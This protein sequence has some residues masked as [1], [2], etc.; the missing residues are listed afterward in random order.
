M[1][2]ARANAK[3][4][5]SASLLLALVAP[6]KLSSAAS[7][8]R[9]TENSEFYRYSMRSTILIS[10]SFWG[11]FWIDGSSPENALHSYAKIAKIGGLEP[12]ENAAKSWLSSLQ[13][14]WLLLI[15]NADDQ[16]MD[17]MRNF[18]GGERGIIVIT[19]RNPT[20]IMYGTEDKLC[21]HFEKLEEEEAGDLLLA[22]AAFPRPW[23][24]PT[25][26]Q[27][28][29]VAQVL[30][31]LPLALIHAGKAILEKLCSLGDYTEYYERSWNKIRRNR[32]RSPSRGREVEISSMRVYS[33]YEMIY[34]GL[35]SKQDQRSKDALQLLKIFSFFHRENIEL[36]LLKTAAMNPRREREDA[37]GKEQDEVHV[38]NHAAPRGWRLFL[39]D[40]II[41]I[42]GQL[43]SPNDILPE[44]LRDD[45]DAPF[46]EDRLRL[47]L[48]LLV[49]L[50]M[51]TLQDE[52]NSYWMHPLVHTWVRQ[53][54]GTS[55]AEQ[56]IWCRAAA[57]VLAQ[58]VLFRAPRAYVARNER[59]QRQ[60]RLHVEHVLQL[61]DTIS[62]RFVENQAAHR[63]PWPLSWLIP[64]PR[65]GVF[66][67][68]EYAKFSLVYL[69]CGEYTK[70]EKLQLQV[71]DYLFTNLGPISKSGIDIALLLS[72]NYVLQTR[73]NEA[74][75]L[76]RQALESA[77]QYYGMDHPKTLQVMDTLG[78]T[79][80]MCSR[81]TEAKKLHEEVIE[82]LSGL[83]KFGPD[84]EST[85]TAVDNLSKV[86]LRFFDNVEAV[87]L[88]RQA[89]M[90]FEKI[91]GPSHQKTLEAKDNLAGIYGYI[92]EDQLPLAHQMSDEVL[93]IRTRD[94]GR[95]HPFTLKSMLTLAKIKTAL[96][97][98]EEAEAIFLEG[99]PAAER[100]LGDSHLGTLTARVWLAHLYWRQGKYSKAATIWED[101]IEKRNFQQSKREDGE[102][103]DRGRWGCSFSE[104]KSTMIYKFDNA[105]LTIK[106]NM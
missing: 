33:S 50:G 42:A 67:A 55:T 74:R 106:P 80:L 100:N 75:A 62:R 71:K 97:Q 35:E 102:H 54:P 58:S 41:S 68:T 84:H 18:P 24:V 37:Q 103:G 43:A 21:F 98:F 94:L 13:H 99:L 46:D 91:L 31:Y 70:A 19:T 51:V 78:A 101:V 27:A 39:M 89:Y 83:E 12:N 20:N 93:Q 48:S 38:Q 5:R 17:L 65:F 10:S 73:N 82:K 7:L 49:R 32:S 2:R 59:M 66:E 4:T 53:R 88:Q 79:C 87:R 105:L 23:E 44:V 92:G 76:Q 9:I 61:Q 14:P 56:A 8:L 81:V 45:D 52:N 85:W 72:Q 25:K 6:V 28:V 95:E 104:Q 22:A 15:D 69:Q 3:P 47:A 86:K 77:Q 40:W 11:I 36:D 16:D 90:G 26:Q 63:R 60:I 34:V 30:G 57:T 64:Q 29:K 96:N 1:S